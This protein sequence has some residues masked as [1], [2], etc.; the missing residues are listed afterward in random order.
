VSL[1]G[2]QA[3]PIAKARVLSSKGVLEAPRR[4]QKCVPFCTETP[5]ANVYDFL[6]NRPRLMKSGKKRNGYC[7]SEK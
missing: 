7:E 4:K 2:I 1:E 3:A 5:F 6:L